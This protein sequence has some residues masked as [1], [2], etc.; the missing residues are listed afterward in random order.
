MTSLKRSPG[1]AARRLRQ[2]LLCLPLLVALSAPVLAREKIDF[3]RLNN[4]DQL[5]CEIIGLSSG[6]LSVRTAS[7]G[8]VE[9]ERA[10]LA[11]LVS[12]QGFEVEL[13]DGQRII[14]TLDE[15]SS[16]GFLGLHPELGTMIEIPFEQVFQIRQVGATFWTR[17][18]GRLNVGLDYGSSDNL[19]NFTLDSRVT[20]QRRTLRL[21][22][23]LQ[24]TTSS[25]DDTSTTERITAWSDLEVP[26]SR[27]FS[28]AGRA[29]YERN[30]E[31]ALEMRITL[32]GALLWL[33]WRSDRGRFAGGLGVAQSEE[34]YTDAGSFSNTM[35]LVYLNFEAYRFGPY[36]TEFSSEV[37]YFYGFSGESRN[38]FEARGSVMQK[39]SHDFNVA[40]TPYYS[41][42]SRNPV[43]G[44]E[45]EDWGFISS[46][47]WSF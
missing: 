32:S 8:T 30:S 31:L 35:G 28:Y 18:R 21:D 7:F 47:G 3:V 9:I 45:N 39:I 16:E 46:I 34:E 43:E 15:G 19:T 40:V 41:Y 27:R 12:V 6:Y 5:S 38:R 2:A 36:G 23:Y 10:K 22:N 25:D 4:G 44:V 29:A 24:A 26:I 42:D 17:R 1:F 37:V 14:T 20:Y 13:A 33:P 11:A